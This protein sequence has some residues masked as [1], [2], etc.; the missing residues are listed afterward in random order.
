MINAGNQPGNSDEC[1]IL[2]HG[3]F[4]TRMS[5]RR[6]EKHLLKLGYATLNLSY[7]STRAPIRKL[8][9]S[10]LATWVSKCLAAGA[11][12]IHF[13]THSMGGIL[14]RQYLENHFLPPDSRLVML[15]PPNQGTE[16][17]DILR[18]IW[19][20]DVIVGPAGLELGTGPDSLPN[21]LGRASIQVGVIAGERSLNPIFSAL[22]PGP[23]DGKV[24]VSRTR[25][26]GMSDFLVV[27]CTH[28]FIMF[29]PEVVRQT[30]NFLVKGHFDHTGES[31]GST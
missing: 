29:N 28:T 14:V 25:M 12:R 18:N 20:F 24:P 4:R 10:H 1:V 7:P 5:M 11:S 19:G 6:L 27:P 16:I 31:G 13:V 3:L 30:A 17:V 9:E 2:L 21:R 8:A 26:D 15:S 22:I 23:D